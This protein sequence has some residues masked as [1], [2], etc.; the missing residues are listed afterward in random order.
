MRVSQANQFLCF[1]VCYFVFMRKTWMVRPPSL[2]ARTRFH[3][4]MS[5]RNSSCTYAAL[6]ESKCGRTLG[7]QAEPWRSAGGQCISPTETRHLFTIHRSVTREGVAEIPSPELLWNDIKQCENLQTQIND[8]SGSSSC[9]W[10]ATV[11]KILGNASCL[12][13][14]LLF[15]A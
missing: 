13:I 10:T 12:P 5:E 11:D 15:Q 6:T 1:A 9:Q 8:F 7:Q 3:D 14:L 2:M 4:E